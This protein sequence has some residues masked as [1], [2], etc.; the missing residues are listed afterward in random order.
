LWPSLEKVL[1]VLIHPP[2]RRHLFPSPSLEFLEPKVENLV[3]T[4]EATASQ[5]E[6]AATDPSKGL[7]EDNFSLSMYNNLNV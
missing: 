4:V 1:E 7:G 6:V 5:V 3:V 2:L